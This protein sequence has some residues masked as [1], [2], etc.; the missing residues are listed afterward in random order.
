MESSAPLPFTKIVCT[1]GPASS[2]REMLERLIDAGLDVAR[3]NFS[4]GDHE[5]HAQ[6]IRWIREIA[7]EKGKAVA[8]LQDLQGPKI[9][10]GKLRG[11]GVTLVRGQRLILRYGVDQ[12]D[13]ALPI[14]YRELAKDT[15]VGAKILLDDGLM[16]MKVTDIRGSDVEVEVV[17]GGLLKPRKGVNFPD[18]SLSI[19]STTEKDTRD[20]LFGVSQGVDY[21]ALSFVRRPDDVM[22]L[23][24]ML[25]A[26]GADT[27]VVSKIEM[28]EAV[29]NIDAICDV[30]DA[31][32][33]ARGDLGVECGFANVAAYQKIIVAAARKKGKPVIVATQMLDSM[34]ENRRPTKAEV[35]DVA[36]AVFDLA[37]ATMLSGETASGRHPELVVRT[38]RELLDGVDRSGLLSK[39]SLQV[40]NREGVADSPEIFARTAAELATRTNA[41][42]IVCLSLSGNVARLVSKHRPLVPIIALSPR[43]DVIRRLSLVR[44]VRG[45]QNTMFFD[46]DECISDVGRVLA[47]QGLVKPGELIVIT[48]GIPLAAMKPTNVIKLHRVSASDSEALPHAAASPSAAKGSTGAPAR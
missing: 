19:P 15:H 24:S 44:G 23:K 30:S 41:A 43:P 40:A 22:K 33:V 16:A 3:L 36:N 28:L 11:G 2:N 17:H 4:H 48:A 5:T 6:N 29:D 14:D 35:C 37:D 20:L 39:E 8:I 26:L 1:L 7:K 12:V 18:S 38:M 42:A 10:T 25:R 46:T 13:D 47:K 27:P 21:V 34:I 9:R 32:M 45:L 31:I